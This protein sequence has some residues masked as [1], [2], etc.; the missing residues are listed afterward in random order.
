[1]GVVGVDVGQQR[2]HDGR[3]SRTQVLGRQT[4]EV[5]DGKQ[6]MERQNE[7]RNVTPTSWNADSPVTLSG[8]TRG[9]DF[10]PQTRRHSPCAGSRRERP[11]D[12]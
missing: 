12:G 2:G 10:P 5:A 6:V 8:T 3:H 7:T 1:M 9:G 11:A 4:V